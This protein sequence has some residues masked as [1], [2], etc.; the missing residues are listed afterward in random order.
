[1]SVFLLQER[2]KE[3][4]EIER[5]ALDQFHSAGICSAATGARLAIER[6]LVSCESNAAAL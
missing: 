1:M 5:S 6:E 4:L 2:V 3:E